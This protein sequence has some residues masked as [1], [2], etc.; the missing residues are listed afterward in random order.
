[1]PKPNCTCGPPNLDSKPFL[2][3]TCSHLQTTVPSSM[4]EAAMIGAERST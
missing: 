4:P 3:G 2:N 1:M